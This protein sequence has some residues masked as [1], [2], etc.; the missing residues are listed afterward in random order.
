MPPEIT[1][2]VARLHRNL[3]RLSLAQVFRSDDAGRMIGIAA[4]MRDATVQF[5]ELRALRRQLTHPAI[6]RMADGRP[7]SPRPLTFP[8]RAN[9]LPDTRNQLFFRRSAS[10]PRPDARRVRRSRKS[11]RCLGDYDDADC[12]ICQHHRQVTVHIPL[13]V[14]A[15]EIRQLGSTRVIGKL[16]SPSVAT[17]V[18]VRIS[19]PTIRI[20]KN[21]L[22][23]SAT[24][25]RRRISG[26]D[27]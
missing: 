15:D 12:Q 21:G 11:Q 22:I 13:V 20:I 4:V 8:C 9:A 6:N 27:V 3:T 10:I 18:T 7:W 16:E 2:R 14:G 17:R 1:T 19:S 25:S 23:S 26:S 5:A 24:R